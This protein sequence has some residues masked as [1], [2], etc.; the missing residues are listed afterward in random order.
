M[1]RAIMDEQDLGIERR[2]GNPAW[3]PGVSGNP[4]GRPKGSRNKASLL[5]EA[6]M[7]DDAAA[8]GQSA[9][10]LAK[11]GNQAA[12]RLCVTRLCPPVRERT[13]DFDLPAIETLADAG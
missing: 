11:A 9:I 7:A 2:R 5:L 6:M 12:L 8:I 10:A 3:V 1:G 13:V 4:A